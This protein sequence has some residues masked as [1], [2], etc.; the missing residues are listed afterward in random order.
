MDDRLLLRW[1]QRVLFGWWPTN[2][3]IDKSL[4][5]LLDEEGLG[6]QERQEVSSL[7]FQATRHWAQLASRNFDPSR[8]EERRDFETSLAGFLKDSRSTRLEQR[9]AQLKPSFEKDARRHLELNHG[10]V[11]FLS[12]GISDVALNSLHESLH[13][14]MAPP[15][16]TVRL[17]RKPGRGDVEAKLKEMGFQPSEFLED[18]WI[19][20]DTKPA[21]RL[22]S[23]V[24]HALEIQDEH[25]QLVAQFCNLDPGMRV[26]D[27]CAGAGGKTL[28]LAELSQGKGEI[29]AFD[30]IP[31]KR[32]ELARRC[33]LAGYA[34]VRIIDQAQQLNTIE[35]DL[36]LADLPCTGLGTLRRRPDYLWKLTASRFQEHLRLQREIVSRAMALKSRRVFVSTCSIHPQENTP[37]NLSV[38]RRSW[39][40]QASGVNS[41]LLLE[42]LSD[43]PTASILAD[44]IEGPWIQ[45]GPTQGRRTS[46]VRYGDGFYIAQVK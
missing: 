3:S 5:R 32:K 13:Q 23:E 18:A 45:L 46:G 38:S 21:A 26:L 33:R 17:R 11:G 37:T 15:V 2:Q 9:H 7:V 44:R 4:K 12:D 16:L 42:S 6:P 43:D 10:F 40:G 22:A 28:H 39:I 31:E 1:S 8:V 25:S 24:G 29:F 34:N 36:V 27:L 35:F 19:S 20:K 41:L 14:Q 30:P